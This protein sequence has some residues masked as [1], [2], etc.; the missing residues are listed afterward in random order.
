MADIDRIAPPIPT[1]PAPIGRGI[2]SQRRRPPRGEPAPDSEHNDEPAADPL[3]PTDH[4][5]EY[6]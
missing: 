4:I 6:A 2:G 1:L 5:D 3:A